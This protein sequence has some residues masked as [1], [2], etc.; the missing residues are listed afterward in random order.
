MNAITFP[1]LDPAVQAALRLRM[2]QASRR[3]YHPT[4]ALVELPAELLQFTGPMR[5]I[6]TIST[7]SA[8]FLTIEDAVA[9]WKGIAQDRTPASA[10]V[11]DRRADRD[12]RVERAL[13][14]YDAAVRVNCTTE[15]LVLELIADSAGEVRYEIEEAASLEGLELD[16]DE[17]VEASRI[18]RGRLQE[19]A[20]RVG[21]TREEALR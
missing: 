20:G 16:E 17:T 11:E 4:I 8:D 9:F 14:I 3:G 5:W 15:A 21:F 12:A 1:N 6:V 19:L 10:L 7:Y 13:E 2:I 18:Y